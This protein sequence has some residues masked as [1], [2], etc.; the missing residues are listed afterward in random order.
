M[1]NRNNTYLILLFITNVPATRILDYTVHITICV[2]MVRAFEVSLFLI[3]SFHNNNNNN[4][5]TLLRSN[6]SRLCY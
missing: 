2:V 4:I 6:Y 3:K 5:S 1:V